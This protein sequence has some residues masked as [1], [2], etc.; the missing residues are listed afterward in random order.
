ALP[1]VERVRGGLAIRHGLGH[2]KGVGSEAA[3]AIVAARAAGPFTS[4]NDVVDRLRFDRRAVEN[5]VLSGAC[6]GLGERR[7]LLWDLAAAFELVK[8]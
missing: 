1:T 6:D 7:A 3:E 8:R 2:V 4:L 5:L